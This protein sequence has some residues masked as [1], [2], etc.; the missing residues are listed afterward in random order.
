MFACDPELDE[1][2]ELGVFVDPQAAAIRTTDAA[3]AA[4]VAFLACLITMTSRICPAAVAA[5]CTPDAW[6][7][8]CSASARAKVNT[9]GQ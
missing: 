9:K 4:W 5:G 2:D 1:P 3:R 6:H 7:R 8:A